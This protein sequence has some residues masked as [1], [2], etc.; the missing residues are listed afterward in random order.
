MLLIVEILPGSSVPHER[1]DAVS[2]RETTVRLSVLVNDWLTKSRAYESRRNFDRRRWTD[3]RAHSPHGARGNPVPMALLQTSKPINLPQT[4][5][6]RRSSCSARASCRRPKSS[7]PRCWRCAPTISRRCTCSASSSCNT[8]IRSARLQLMIGGAARRGRN[9]PR[10]CSIMASSSTRSAATTTRSRF[11]IWCCRSSVGR[12]RRSTIAAPCWRSSAAT[13]RRW[14]PSSARWRSSP[15]HTDTLYN[16]ASVLRKL[17]R[18][19]EAL[20]SFDRVLAMRAGLRQ[21]AQ[22]PRH[23]ARG[24]GPARRGAGKL[25][26]GARARRQFCRSAQ[27]PRQ[28]AA[29]ARPPGGCP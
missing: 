10:C 15:G 19:D 26:P 17:G 4:V 20:K 21:G 16:Q 18:H 23:G 14:S 3:S 29:Q 5:L 13:R 9:R 24:A 1:S 22:Q 27:Q 2:L 11:S 8:A 7:I 6:S 25:R 28:C 12:S